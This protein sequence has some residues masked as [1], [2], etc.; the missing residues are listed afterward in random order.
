MKSHEEPGAAA[1]TERE[2]RMGRFGWFVAAAMAIVGFYVGKGLGPAPVSFPEAEDAL[3][4]AEMEG[5]VARVLAG[6]RAFP[7]ASALVRLCEGLTVENVEGA[8]RAIRSRAGENDP[9]DL[10][11]FLTAWTHLDPTAAMREVQG[12]PIRSRREIGIRTVMREWAA[13]GRQLEAGN[14]FDSLSDPDQRALAAVPLVR[15]WALS[16]DTEGALALARRFWEA[17]GRHDV[18]DGLMRGVLHAQGAAGTFALARRVDPQTGDEFA[19]AVARTA[20]G[21]AGREDPPAAAAYYDE[22][23]ESGSTSWLEGTLVRLAGL[24][25]N[26]SPAAALEWLVPKAEGPERSRAL[27][28][29]MGTW[30]KRDFDTAWNWFETHREATR[31]D[32]ASPLTPTDSALL[33]G[34]VRRMARIRPAEAAAWAMKL[35]PGADRVEMLRRVAYFWS[36]GDATAADRWIAG[37][38]VPAKELAQVR[39]AAEW[40]R[41]GAH[42]ERGD[43][44]AE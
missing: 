27:T 43:R 2:S 4:A 36:M 9:V 21:L 18:V 32:S 24:L 16:G 42:S 31:A 37:L 3:N 35:R 15:G 39:E 25:R 12:W 28:E 34:L 19:Q 40:G 5:Q 38:V 11:I 6:P 13:S 8:A 26:E 1:I 17:E 41:S 7:R 10:Q 33:S 14:Y 22:L 30:A 23:S 29:T 44:I 20:L